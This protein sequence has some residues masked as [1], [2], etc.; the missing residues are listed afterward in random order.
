MKKIMVAEEARTFFEEKS[1][2]ERVA[3]LKKENFET[4]ISD[5]L[6][7]KATIDIAMATFSRENVEKVVSMAM[8]GYEETCH[9]IH[10]L[11][12]IDKEYLLAIYAEIENAEEPFASPKDRADLIKAIEVELWFHI[13]G[14]E[15][16][17]LGSM[18]NVGVQVCKKACISSFLA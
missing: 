14:R 9:I 1:F 16:T 13:A 12:E 18:S 2:K 3:Y 5:E 10:N 7:N 6:R 17:N 4:W 11:K 15:L 8:A